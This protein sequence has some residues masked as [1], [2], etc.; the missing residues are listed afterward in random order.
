MGLIA[1]CESVVV[2]GQSLLFDDVRARIQSIESRVGT[3]L[4]DHG[5]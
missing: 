4:S 3:S 1:L 5:T 2:D